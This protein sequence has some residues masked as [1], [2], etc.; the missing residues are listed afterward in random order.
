[1]FKISQFPTFN[2]ILNLT[3]VTINSRTP[4]NFYIFYFS[5]AVGEYFAEGDSTKK[6]PCMNKHFYTNYNTIKINKVLIII[7]KC[8]TI[9]KYG[10]I[11]EPEQVKNLTSYN[12]SSTSLSLKWD[13]P[14]GNYSAF[15][16]QRLGNT[17]FSL[18]VPSERN[19]SDSLVQ[20]FDNSTS[21]RIIKS[22]VASI[23]GLTPGNM[24]T[25][26]ITALVGESNIQGDSASLSSYTMPGR[27]KNLTNVCVT[28]HTVSL[29]WQPPEGNFSFY[30]F[31]IPQFPTFNGSLHVENVT[32]DNLTP[33]NFYTFWG[34]FT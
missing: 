26:F 4:G 10:S 33:G 19:A 25:F 17:S 11:T 6:S 5:A 18:S 15:L 2:A 22:K 1:M 27:I 23:E 12:I 20:I 24:Y 31:R 30:V 28:E 9:Q 7:V 21:S 32:A 16:I 14:N 34:T 3:S 8:S 29:S 13:P